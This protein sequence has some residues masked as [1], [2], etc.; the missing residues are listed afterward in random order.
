MPLIHLFAYLNEGLW[1]RDSTPEEVGLS[2]ERRPNANLKSFVIFVCGYEIAG[3][4]KVKELWFS[5]ISSARLP[6]P[7]ERLQVRLKYNFRMKKKCD[8]TPSTLFPLICYYS[9]K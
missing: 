9:E 1:D 5:W 3:N 6:A 2:T 8:H 4:K 7:L